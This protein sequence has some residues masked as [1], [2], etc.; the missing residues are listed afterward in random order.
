MHVNPREF[1]GPGF[2]LGAGCDGGV[3]VAKRLRG[4][5][6]RRLK[7]SSPA[8]SSSRSRRSRVDGMTVD[9]VDRLMRSFDAGTDVAMTLRP[10]LAAR[11]F[12]FVYSDQLPRFAQ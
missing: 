8:T 2:D 7:G 1:V 3:F 12:T 10:G 11:S 9:E 4:D 5:L 6:R